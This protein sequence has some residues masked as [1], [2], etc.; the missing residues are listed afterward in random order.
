MSEPSKYPNFTAHD[1]ERYHSGKMSGQERNAI[2]RAALEDPFLSDAL[3]GY[4]HT[5]TAASDLEII[6][7]RLSEK[8][9]KKKTPIFFRHN[10]FMKAA[11]VILLVVGAGW[12]FYTQMDSQPVN[13]LA[14]SKDP[15][16]KTEDLPVSDSP[17]INTGNGLA[18]D[19]GTRIIDLVQS[20]KQNEIEKTD[21]TFTFSTPAVS[22]SVQVEIFNDTIQALAKE[23]RIKPAEVSATSTSIMADRMRKDDSIPRIAA[24]DVPGVEIKGDSIKNLN[25]VMLENDQQLNEVIVLN[26]TKL[27]GVANQPKPIEEIEPVGGWEGY[28]TYALSNLKPPEGSENKFQTGDVVLSFDTDKDG[29]PVNI[30]VVESFCTSCEKEARRILQ[31]GPRWKNKNLRNAK[32]RIKF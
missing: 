26:R 30:K 3:E 25:I 18:A 8:I 10:V 32:I 28:N 16:S 19:S 31:E 2:E 9:N 14:T 6:R 17:L 12:W 24:A 20:S 27:R 4:Q 15:A 29:E 5:A 21:N 7:R 22:N 23:N 13:S 1:I 11:A